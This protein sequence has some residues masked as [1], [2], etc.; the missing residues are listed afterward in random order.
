MKK[1]MMLAAT[2]LACTVMAQEPADGPKDGPRH[3]KMDR[4]P[5]MAER[6]EHGQRGPQMGGERGPMA[7]GMR[8]GQMGGM[9]GG[10]MGGNPAEAAVMSVLN[11]K[12][13]EKI[14]LSEEVRAQI[15][16]IDGDSRAATRELQKKTREAMEKQA[17]LMSE[18]TSDEASVMAAIDELFELRK[19]MAKH[20][21]RRVFAIKALLTSE[22]LAAAT[23]EM[24]KFREERRGRRANGPDAGARRE[25]G[26]GP[27]G[28]PEGRAH[29]GRPEGDGHEGRPEGD[30]LPPPAPEAE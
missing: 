6:G 25:G 12:I 8:G 29:E 5:Q 18:P 19:E 11:P 27:E 23:E 14:G 15:K 16:K 26:R 20:Q 21:T 4:G 17:K 30:K 2:A 9:M 1:L 7:G 22:Q 28:R 13:A 24:K 10:M 3:G